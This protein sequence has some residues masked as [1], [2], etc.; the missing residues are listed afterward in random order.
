MPDPIGV[1]D[2]CASFGEHA[3]NGAL[4]GSDSAREPDD[5]H[6]ACRTSGTSRKD[7]GTA[8]PTRA[9]S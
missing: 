4:P 6:V 9:V 2:P 8:Q 7:R 1:D 3:G 5:H